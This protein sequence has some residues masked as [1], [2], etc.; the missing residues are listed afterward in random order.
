[1]KKLLLVGIAATAMLASCSNDETVGTPEQ[2]AAISFSSFVDKSTRAIVSGKDMQDDWAVWGFWDKTNKVFD[3]VPQKVNASGIYSPTQYWFTKRT[4]HFVGLSPYDAVTNANVSIEDEGVNVSLEFTNTNGETD[5]LYTK[6]DTYG[7][8]MIENIPENPVQMKFDHMLSKVKFT[9]ENAMVTESFKFIVS[10]IK[11]T[12]ARK[13]AKLKIYGENKEWNELNG[14]MILDF[15]E[16]N[17]GNNIKVNANGSSKDLLIIPSNGDVEYNVNFTLTLYQGETEIDTY[18]H[19]STIKNVTFE[20]GKSY[21]FKATITPKNVN[22]DLDDD[23]VDTEIKFTPE[24]NP[25]ETPDVEEEIEN[26]EKSD[27]STEE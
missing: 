19:T 20:K 2:N 21:N 5:L 12:N 16:A 6:D 17:N 8:E 15:A 3:N 24:V 4:Y 23:V 22:P 14:S 18:S 26:Y 11:I 7:D 1:M 27:D 10:Q 25:W 9:F 13:T